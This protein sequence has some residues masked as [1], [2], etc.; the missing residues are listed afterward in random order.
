MTFQILRKVCLQ[1]LATINDLLMNANEDRRQSRLS[2]PR[3]RLGEEYSRFTF[4]GADVS[5]CSWKRLDEEFAWEKLQQ[6]ET[7]YKKEFVRC[8]EHIDLPKN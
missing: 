3:L 2:E 1:N 5:K 4:N 6:Y 8:Q 7:L